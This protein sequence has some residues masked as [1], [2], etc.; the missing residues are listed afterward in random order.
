LL[1]GGEIDVPVLIDVSIIAD[2][3]NVIVPRR[4]VAVKCA[5]ICDRSKIDAVHID[6]CEIEALRR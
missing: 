1:A 6:V 2:W 4:D 5:A 3:R